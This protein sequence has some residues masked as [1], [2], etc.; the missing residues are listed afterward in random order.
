MHCCKMGHVLYSVNFIIPVVICE[1]L[2][3][4]EYYNDPP[5]IHELHHSYLLTCDLAGSHINFCYLYM[6]SVAAISSLL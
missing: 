1:R 2:E 3:A 5:H 6:W 4:F